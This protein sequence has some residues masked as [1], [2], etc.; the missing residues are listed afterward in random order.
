MASASSEDHSPGGPAGPGDAAATPVASQH[1]A[2]CPDWSGTDVG[3]L[4][5]LPQTPHTETFERVWRIVL[6]K[7]AD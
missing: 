2:E 1:A 6:V 5:S 7:R 4:A 3:S